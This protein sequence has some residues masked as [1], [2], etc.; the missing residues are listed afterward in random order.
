[1]I[2]DSKTGLKRIRLV[3]AVI[4]AVMFAFTAAEQFR[5]QGPQYLLPGVLLSAV[6]GFVFLFAIMTI[7]IYLIR[8]FRKGD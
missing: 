8:L 7:V 1:M 5:T 4:G 6:I 3:S 2:Q